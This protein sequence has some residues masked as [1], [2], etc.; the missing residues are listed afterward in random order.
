[1]RK[2]GKIIKLFNELI[3][4][5]NFAKSNRKILHFFFCVFVLL[6]DTHLLV[7][8]EEIKKFKIFSFFPIQLIDT[9]KAKK[10]KKLNFS[11]L[12]KNLINFLA[13]V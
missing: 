2:K 13:V 5:F 3:M 10:K 1:M 6:V 11:F 4:V 7:L 8:C 12:I 9:N